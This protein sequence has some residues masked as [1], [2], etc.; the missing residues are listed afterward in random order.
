MA[1]SFANR[2]VDWEDSNRLA[3]SSN[4]TCSST[5]YILRYRDDP[6]FAAFCRK[7]GLP[8]PGRRPRASRPDRRHRL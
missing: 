5:L 1:H 6:R 4:C 2:E 3:S 8:V 7:V